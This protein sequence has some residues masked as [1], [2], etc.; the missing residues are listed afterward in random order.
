MKD[1]D[2]LIQKPR[3]EDFDSFETFEMAMEIWEE[4]M[5]KKEEAQKLRKT[6]KNDE[7][8]EAGLEKL[9]FKKM[10]DSDFFDEKHAK[11]IS[12]AMDLKFFQETCNKHFFFG[13]LAEKDLIL[14]EKMLNSENLIPK[15]WIDQKTL[16]G[17]LLEF[18]MDLFEACLNN[19]I[20]K[21]TWNDA[22]LDKTTQKFGRD[23][24][25]FLKKV[26]ELDEKSSDDFPKDE[27]RRIVEFLGNKTFAKTK[28][29]RIFR[30]FLE[31]KSEEEIAKI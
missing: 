4:M 18:S 29:A 13:L 22:V 10:S 15:N 25:F 23:L 2:F 21:K 20:F 11:S 26:L 1:F 3:I 16:S 31:G 28:N 5:Q 19:Q 12:R 17:N 8:F 9:G 7:E 6:A 14:S 24:Y 27:L 30:A